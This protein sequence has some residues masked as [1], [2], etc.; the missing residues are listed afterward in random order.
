MPTT[1]LDHNADS[2]VPLIKARAYKEGNLGYFYSSCDPAYSQTYT[3][4]IP[5]FGSNLAITS[6]SYAIAAYLAAIPRHTSIPHIPLRNIPHL[7]KYGIYLINFTTYCCIDC[8]IFFS[9]AKSCPK[10]GHALVHFHCSPPVVSIVCHYHYHHY[11]RHP[12]A[13]ERGQQSATSP[14]MPN[15][16]SRED[17]CNSLQI[18]QTRRIH[19]MVQ[20]GA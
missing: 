10:Q 18:G 8:Q 9:N 3:S 11:L 5:D 2:P 12:H 13:L 7:A 19:K 15:T 1:R 4:A 20:A 14:P 17:D 6:V 16:A